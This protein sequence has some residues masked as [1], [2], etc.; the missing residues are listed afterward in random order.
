[1]EEI[2]TKQE[3]CDILGVNK[4]TLKKIEQKGQLSDRPKLKGYEFISNSK[5]GRNC[6]Y[7][8]V[9]YDENIKLYTDICDNL[10]ETKSYSKTKCG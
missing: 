9:S 6:E 3:I 7:T 5:K 1:M 4:E 10:F 8:I 2:K